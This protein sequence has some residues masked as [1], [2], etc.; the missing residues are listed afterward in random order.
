MSKF[1]LQNQF[2]EIPFQGMEFVHFFTCG[3]LWSSRTINM[4]LPP[5]YKLCLNSIPRRGIYRIENQLFT[6]FY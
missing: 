1:S 3:G 4:F 5:L 6:I 2:V